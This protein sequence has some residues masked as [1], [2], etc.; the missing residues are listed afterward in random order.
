MLRLSVAPRHLRP[1]LNLPKP[2]TKILR[3]A[4]RKPCVMP[5]KPI[6]LMT[7]SPRRQKKKCVKS[8]HDLNAAMIA[9]AQ[10]LLQHR[11]L[12]TSRQNDLIALCHDWPHMARPC[13]LP[14][15]HDPWS[16][17]LFLGGRGAGKTR[18]GAEWV[19]RCVQK[20]SQRIALVGPSYADVRE[21]MIEGESGLRNIGYPTERP[22]YES[23][24]RRL[25]WPN[26]AV[27]YV[28]SSQ[29]PDGLRGPQ[30]DAAWADEFC[31]WAY[32]QE[33]LSNLRFGLRLGEQPKLVMTTTPKPI[34]SLRALIEE[35]GV[36]CTRSSTHAN[37]ANLSRHFLD[38]IVEIY[39]GTRLGRQ[40]LDG[41][42]L[43]DMP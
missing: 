25:V 1:C 42:I 31:A 20:G 29:E 22:H 17:W 41:E 10:P 23:S 2:L 21:V 19:R 26:G 14:P 37:T 27:G 16:V 11:L 30:F 13:Q 24:R 32:P 8:A 12:E 5:T 3:P 36:V 43:E 18:A 4:R 28:F 33:T 39:G 7:N 38:S 9:C 34:A 40:E 6:H 35:F 15:Q